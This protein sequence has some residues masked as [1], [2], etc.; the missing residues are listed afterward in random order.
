MGREYRPAWGRGE[1]RTPCALPICSCCLAHYYNAIRVGLQD[2]HCYKAFIYEYFLQDYPPGPFADMEGNFAVFQSSGRC[3][4]KVG[5]KEQLSCLRG[6]V[7]IFIMYSSTVGSSNMR[8]S[9]AFTTCD[10][11]QRTPSPVEMACSARIS[12][13]RAS[14]SILHFYATCRSSS[15]GPIRIFL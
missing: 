13:D 5:A 7:G 8:S 9:R 12:A 6:S 1:V 2:T 4:H 15:T 3:P 11:I 14:I 10:L